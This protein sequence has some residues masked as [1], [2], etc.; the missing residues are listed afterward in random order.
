MKLSLFAYFCH[1]Y[2]ATL[3]GG[4]ERRLKFTPAG[5]CSE[6]GWEIRRQVTANDQTVRFRFSIKNTGE[7][8]RSLPDIKVLRLN[9]P[10]FC[11]QFKDLAVFRLT[12]ENCDIPG[13][14]HPACPDE[15]MRDALLSNTHPE[16][17]VAASAQSLPSTF[18]ADPGMVLLGSR[19]LFIGFAGQR[20]HFGSVRLSTDKWRR[21][22]VSLEAVAELDQIC[23][24]PGETF[25]CHDLL[26]QCGDTLEAL[27]DQHATRIRS[28]YGSRQA[29]VKAVYATGEC[30][31][32]SISSVIVRRNLDW[33]ARNHLA[34]QV[35]LIDRG[36]EQEPGRWE[37]DP[38]RFPEGMAA[39][40][41]EIRRCGLEPGLATAPYLIHPDSPVLQRDPSLILRDRAGQPRLFHTGAGDCCIL[42]PYAPSAPAYLQKLFG[43]LLGW[44]YRYCRVDF[45]QAVCRPG[46]VS[47]NPAVSRAMAYTRGLQL[48]RDAVGTET[49]LHVGGGLYEA[50]AGLAD[51]VSSG[52]YCQNCP[53]CPNRTRMS[54]SQVRI[55]QNV[56]RS[57]YGGLWTVD[58]GPLNLSRR[59]ST[60]PKPTVQ[61]GCCQ[62]AFTEAESRSLLVNQYLSGGLVHI[63]ECVRQVPAERLALLRLVLPNYARRCVPAATP[64]EYLPNC[65]S[66]MHEREGESWLMVYVC[67]WNGLRSRHLSFRLQE[68]GELPAAERYGVYELFQ[69]RFFGTFSAGESINVMVAAHD[70]IALRVTPLMSGEKIL[71][72]SSF[73]L[74]GGAEI[75]PS[76]EPSRHQG[77]NGTVTLW[78]SGEG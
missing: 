56:S 67:N 60:E 77:G 27:L 10:V 17:G 35:F 25:A 16:S 55:R 3:A 63:S 15:N 66:C 32:P 36:W 9:S 11:R 6:D 54:I 23:L 42:D 19:K 73:N 12:R 43:T 52:T 24:P 75:P 22:V 38:V 39:M 46:V 45:L 72:G 76:G 33:I 13:L 20:R 65:F 28:R 78:Y 21:R 26:V 74:S 59:Q 48:I 68:L 69:S 4:K 14:F 2:Y 34:V 57:F 7:E 37:P 40:A 71:V 61:D 70:V 30:F 29:P 58:P 49:I 41:A 64:G 31:G 1:D 51:I 18:S 50:S 47:C 5:F 62:S 8:A 53:D 44:G